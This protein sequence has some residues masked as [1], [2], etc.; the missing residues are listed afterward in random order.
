MWGKKTVAV[1]IPSREENRTIFDVIQDFDSTGYVDEILVVSDNPNPIIEEQIKNTRAKFIKQ[2]I[3]GFGAAVKT[4]FSS[5]NADLLILTE[6]NRTYKGKDILKLLSYSDDFDVVFGTRT[7]LPLIQKGSGMNLTRRIVDGFLG[8]LVSVL[9][10]SS[11][12]SDIGC[13][14]RLTNKKGWKKVSEECKSNDE[15]FLAQWLIAA[16]KNKVRFIEIPVNFNASSA[17]K[18]KRHYFYYTIKLIKIS[19]CIFKAWFL[20]V[21]RLRPLIA[22][23]QHY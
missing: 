13:P 1:I 22:H 14:V 6:A 19:F 15:L 5:T 8:R 16:A 23:I 3:S 17:S 11:T 21:S 20:H 4:G 9:F 18:L 10:L 2:K 7:H 12:L